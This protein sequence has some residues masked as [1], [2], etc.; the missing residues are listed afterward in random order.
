M[1]RSF[2]ALWLAC[3]LLTAAKIYGEVDKKKLNAPIPKMARTL[4]LQGVDLA[5]RDRVTEALAAFRKAIALAPNYVNAH[6]EYIQVKSNHL[7]RYDEARK[8]YEDL[9]KKEP[10]NPV[11][12]MA[13]AIAQHQTSQTSKNVWLKKVIE[14]AP[15]WFWTPYARA[16]LVIDKEPET[17]VAELDKYIKAGGTW[18]GAYSTLVWTQEKTLKKL[19]DAIATAEKLVKLPESRWWD[20]H[21]LWGFRLG[22]A[23][24][25]DE[26]KTALRRELE[27]LEAVSNEIKILDAIRVAYSSL[28]KDEEKSKKVEAKIRRLDSEW[29]KNR[30]KILYIMAWNA[31]GAA[32]LI[33]GASG[34]YLLWDKIN[35]FNGEMEPDEKIAGLESL[36]SSKISS[37]MKR[38]I[39][40]QIFMV[41]EKSGDTATLVKYGEMLLAIDRADAGVPAKISLTFANKKNVPKA[42]YYA[43]IAE[44]ATA[45][46]RPVSRPANNGFTDE[47]WRKERFPEERQQLYY[48]NLRSLALNAL[49]W[50]VFQAGRLTESE[51][52]LRQSVE[53]ARSERNLGHLAEALGKLGRGEEAERI[54]AEAKNLYTESVKKTLK[55][56]PSKDFE[57]TALDGRRVKLSDLKGKVVMIDFWAT[58]C[59]PCVKSAP[60]LNRLYAKYKERGFEILYVSV[61]AQADIYKVAPF[62]KEHKLEFPVLLD[63]GAKELYNVKV[64]P[65]TIFVDREGNIRH[66]DTGFSEES[67]RLMET[68]AE[69]LLKAN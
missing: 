57:L 64:F 49:G 36:L 53:I 9:M 6:A 52:K 1:K 22:K 29:H 66:R 48:K 12:P 38:Y 4:H 47:E 2:M 26:A 31:S 34:I 60:T 32:R 61:D 59:G 28:L 18:A 20:Y 13:M 5:D 7:G 62:V 54:M 58:W 33:S 21:W 15:Q 35:K 50:A 68:V 42:L 55:K 65:T 44:R 19:D 67:P 16:L 11:Y 37:D 46:F 41:A 40:E 10:N 69:L 30:G 24:G 45:V 39:Y 14:F 43:Q 56:E 25:T 17:A 51:T 3:V 27:Q 23:G 63:Q 8:E